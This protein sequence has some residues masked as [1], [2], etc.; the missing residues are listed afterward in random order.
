MLSRS[1]NP[2]G[3]RRGD[4]AGSRAPRGV[5]CVLRAMGPP[6][7]REV[8]VWYAAPKEVADLA[9]FEALLAPE[10]CERHRRYRFAKDRDLFLLARGMVRLVLARYAGVDPASWR[11]A[12]GPHGK[13]EVAAPADHEALRFN[14]T[15]TDGLVAC[16]VAVGREV[17]IDAEDLGRDIG[18]DELARRYFST[19]ENAQ[20]AQ[21]SQG[22][23]RELFFRFWTLKEA[24]LK[25]R[26]LGL[27]LPL[28]DFSFEL[29]SAGPPTIRFAPG[30][31]DDPLAWQFAEFRPGPRHAL[32]LA[33][34]RDADEVAIALR[35]FDRS[36]F[37]ASPPPAGDSARR[38]P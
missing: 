11:F 26:G 21:A 6:S 34:R 18:C 17:G 8:H 19:A 23:R 24:Y 9:G 36:A 20:L 2:S 22:R 27:G 35:P 16:A 13:P 37:P 12:T 15:H 38:M 10:E 14:L 3:V 33:V 29:S 7:G 31:A 5:F 30:L 28:S 1:R 32:A 25:A 4:G